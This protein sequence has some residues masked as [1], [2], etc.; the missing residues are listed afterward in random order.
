MNAWYVDDLKSFDREILILEMSYVGDL[1]KM[2][3]DELEA[4][5]EGDTYKSTLELASR[6]KVSIP[7]VLNHLKQ[8]GKIKELNQ[9]MVPSWRLSF[10]ALTIPTSHCYL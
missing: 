4:I 10:F 3:N 6:I 1:S 7:T 2:D 5:V 8:I 9:V